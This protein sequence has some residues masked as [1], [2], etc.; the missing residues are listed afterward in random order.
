[1]AIINS[2]RQYNA[3]LVPNHHAV[4]TC[5]VHE[6]LQS[7]FMSPQDAGE[8]T[9]SSSS[10]YNP[11]PKLDRA[12]AQAVSRRPLTVQ[13]RVRTR[14][15]PCSICGV[16]CHSDRFLS[17]LFGFLP[18]SFHCGSPYAYIAWGINNRPVGGR[19]SET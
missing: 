5:G 18:I 12:M 4:R 10:R 15:S 17:Q 3:F 1:V 13:A 16:K 6:C 2:F 11:I 9:A 8:Y 7:F 14:V 19:S